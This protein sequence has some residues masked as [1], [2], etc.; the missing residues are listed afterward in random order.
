MFTNSAGIWGITVTR[1]FY[2]QTRNHNNV[3]S[4]GSRIFPGGAPTP[5][6]LLYFTFLPKTAWK[7]KNLDPRGGAR[8]WRPPLDPPMFITQRNWSQQEEISRLSSQLIRNVTFAS[9]K[10]HSIKPSKLTKEAKCT[11][12]HSRRM[13]TAHLPTI[14]A[15]VATRCQYRWGGCPQVNKRSLE[16]VL[17]S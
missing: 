17:H 10:N 11:R 6:L 13:C 7:W 9:K 14:N 8:P 4:G 2:L 3:H 1:W 12:K 5:K 16:I 15:L